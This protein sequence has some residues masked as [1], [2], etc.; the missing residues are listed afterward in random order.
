MVNNSLDLK[1]IITD[2]FIKSQHL[3]PV[4][5]NNGATCHDMMVTTVHKITAQFIIPMAECIRTKYVRGPKTVPLQ[6]HCVYIYKQCVT[7]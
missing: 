2:L 6:D 4:I 5:Q 7:V 1:L 3:Q